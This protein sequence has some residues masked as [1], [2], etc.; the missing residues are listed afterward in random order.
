MRDTETIDQTARQAALDA[1]QA[2]LWPPLEGMARALTGEYKDADLA[3]V[4]AGMG[5]GRPEPPGASQW[6]ID[7]RWQYGTGPVSATSLDRAC[8]TAIRRREYAPREAGE[9]L[10]EG[11]RLE[12]AL[13]R[14]LRGPSYSR[15]GKERTANSTTFDASLRRLALM[16]KL[17]KRPKSCPSCEGTGVDLEYLNLTELPCPECIGTGR[18]AIQYRK[19]RIGRD[20]CDDGRFAYTLDGTVLDAD[21]TPRTLTMTLTD[22]VEQRAAKV[23]ARAF[24]KRGRPDVGGKCAQRRHKW[25]EDTTQKWCVKCGK[26]A[27]KTKFVP[28]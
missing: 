26:I 11:Q 14:R 5:T 9:G 12:L 8:R 6:H 10:Q 21:S 3:R 7:G 18:R 28:V 15:G 19:P 24:V 20:W 25:N 1:A 27:K 23:R 22:R 2:T 16:G 13:R 4:S 17:S